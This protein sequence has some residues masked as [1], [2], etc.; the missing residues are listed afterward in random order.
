MYAV[1]EFHIEHWFHV[2]FCFIFK[3]FYISGSYMNMKTEAFGTL[4]Q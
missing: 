2:Q 1:L 4:I 3:N